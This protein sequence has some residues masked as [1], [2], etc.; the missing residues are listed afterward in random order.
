MIQKYRAIVT[1]IQAEASC[2]PH[3]NGDYVRFADHDNEI[4]RMVGRYLALYS[5]AAAAVDYM[6][7]STGATQDHEAYKQLIALIRDSR[8][9]VMLSGPHSN[10]NPKAQS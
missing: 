10:F 1:D 6:N 7:D 2:V 3:P 5:A 8:N 9:E 4:C